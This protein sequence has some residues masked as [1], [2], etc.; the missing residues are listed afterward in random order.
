PAASAWSTS[1]SPPGP[2]PRRRP[3][4]GTG[5]SCANSTA[6]PPPRGGPL[7][8]APRPAH[9]SAVDRPAG[10]CQGAQ[11][12]E[13]VALGVGHDH[14]APAGALAH[15]HGGGAE[16]GQPGHLVVG[17]AVD[18][19]DVE[20]E[21]VLHGLVLAAVDHLE[22]QDRAPEGREPLRIVAVDNQLGEPT[23]HLL[24]RTVRTRAQPRGLRRPA[25]RGGA[26]R[27]KPRRRS[28][29]GSRCQSL[30]TLTWR[31]RKTGVPRRASICL[32]DLMP[33]SFRRLP[34][35]PMTM[36]FWLGR[37]EERRVG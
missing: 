4:A 31:S 5:N 15:V 22:V 10:W 12:V 9:A 1:T 3:T 18:R 26:W 34:L 29:F 20:V 30:A 37:S 36:P 35:G 32:R 23:G 11:D 17:A 6:E 19:A 25:G 13:L 14:P 16:A 33:T 2:A 27:Q 24:P 8:S 21:P 7:R 28:C